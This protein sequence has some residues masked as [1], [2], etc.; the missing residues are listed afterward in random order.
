MIYT[1]K[2]LAMAYTAKEFANLDLSKRD[3]KVADCHYCKEPIL[4]SQGK[5]RGPKYFW[6]TDC[7][8][9]DFSDFLDKN[10]IG[11]PQGIRKNT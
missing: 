5:I 4:E 9:D 7:Y 11:I 10:P 6:H 2:E 8:Y 3:S 1:V